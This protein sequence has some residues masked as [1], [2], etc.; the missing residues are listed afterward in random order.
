MSPLFVVKDNRFRLF[1]LPLLLSSSIL[2][3]SAW[4]LPLPHILI[5]EH[6]LR[7]LPRLHFFSPLFRLSI[8]VVV[9][10]VK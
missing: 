8:A 5:L 10:V 1:P 7:F 3:H 6:L 4:A 2:L 9:V